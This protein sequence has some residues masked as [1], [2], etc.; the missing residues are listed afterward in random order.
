[1]PLTLDTGCHELDTYVDI[2]LR[3]QDQPTANLGL[4]YSNLQICYFSRLGNEVE[5]LTWCASA[6][7]ERHEYNSHKN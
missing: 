3:A 5:F 6:V 2:Y 7:E 1:M 4:K